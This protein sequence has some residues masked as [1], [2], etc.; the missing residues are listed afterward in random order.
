MTLTTLGCD[1]LRISWEISH[2]ADSDSR[3][4]G[5][6]TSVKTGCMQVCGSWAF[7]FCDKHGRE[8]TGGKFIM[9]HG[10]WGFSAW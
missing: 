10:L 5:W 4:G 9:A 1:A 6:Y 8:T 2:I 7:C 3:A